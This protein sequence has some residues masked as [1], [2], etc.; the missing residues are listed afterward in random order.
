MIYEINFAD[1]NFKSAQKFN[2]KMAKK[3]GAD[4]VVEYGPDYIDDEFKRENRAILALETVYNKK[5][6]SRNK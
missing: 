3:F 4:V 2:S 5:N 6:V 1:D